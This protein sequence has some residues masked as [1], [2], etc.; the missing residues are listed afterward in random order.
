MT[1]EGVSM[2]RM[3]TALVLTAGFAA[4]YLAGSG[5]GPELVEKLRAQADAF[6]G[7]DGIGDAGQRLAQAAGDV[8]HAA[9][10][11]VQDVSDDVATKVDEVAD[12]I[13]PG[14]SGGA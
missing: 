3:R 4:G 12:R 13:A 2:L 1:T 6:L 7:A 10:A 9:S 5:R 8:A 11:R 14:A